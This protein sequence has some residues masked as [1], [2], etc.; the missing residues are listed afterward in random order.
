MNMTFPSTYFSDFLIL[1]G[2]IDFTADQV[3]SYNYT[4]LFQN[5]IK[6]LLLL[7]N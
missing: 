3:V 6:F 2:Y 1:P 5:N 4:Q 7:C